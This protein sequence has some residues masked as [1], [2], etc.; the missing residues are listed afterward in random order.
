MSSYTKHHRKYMNT[1]RDQINAHRRKRYFNKQ[2]GIPIEKY[3]DFIGIFNENRVNYLRFCKLIV[4]L[5]Q[6]SEELNP[7]LV[8]LLQDRFS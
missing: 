5:H 1:H 3:D 4:T 6:M 7:D 2:Y 8:Q